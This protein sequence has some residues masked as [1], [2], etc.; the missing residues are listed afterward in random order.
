MALAAE[1]LA[2]DSDL[3]VLP[4]PAGSLCQRRRLLAT[5]KDAVAVHQPPLGATRLD[6]SVQWPV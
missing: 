2:D 6:L 3:P 5:L 4:P 1:K